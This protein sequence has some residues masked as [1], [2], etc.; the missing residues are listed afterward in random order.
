MPPRTSFDL[1]LDT[2][3]TS[4]FGKKRQLTFDALALLVKPHILK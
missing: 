1:Y 3:S 2:F 4:A